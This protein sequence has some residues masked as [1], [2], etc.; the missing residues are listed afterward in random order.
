MN[1]TAQQSLEGIERDVEEYRIQ[2][3]ELL[4]TYVRINAPCTTELRR[5]KPDDPHQYAYS[6][7]SGE[8]SQ[9]PDVDVQ[10]ALTVL[11]RRLRLRG[12][13]SLDLRRS[14][15]RNTNPVGADL[16]LALLSRSCI[17]GANL[18]NASF[19]MAD[20]TGASMSGATLFGADLRAK[21]ALRHNPT[22]EE[23]V[24]MFVNLSA[25]YLMEARLEGNLM[26]DT[27]FNGAHLSAARLDGVRCRAGVDF[28]NAVL[29]C[30]HLEGA[31]L[32][33]ARGLLP[34]SVVHSFAN[35]QTRFPKGIDPGRYRTFQDLQGK[36][37]SDCGSWERMFDQD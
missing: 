11:G 30:A 2:V 37:D 3:S 10:A 7:P 12:D 31:S 28:T 20:L 14:D 18:R 19:H 34:K 1:G 15:L 35:S 9:K 16:S 8:E 32:K 29:N 25:A 4:A 5:D 36:T 33:D 21:R 6:P 24:L 26:D 22:L 13:P 17:D 27:R 23:P